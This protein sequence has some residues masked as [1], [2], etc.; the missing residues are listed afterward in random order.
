M[1]AYAGSWHMP[2]ALHLFAIAH[3][4]CAQPS[5]FELTRNS[6]LQTIPLTF[7]LALVSSPLVERTDNSYGGFSFD[8]TGDGTADD[9]FVA[10]FDQANEVLLSDGAGGYSRLESGPLVERTDTSYG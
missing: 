7:H 10:N 9:V 3:T 8:A 2:L 4:S 1:M 5:T 6:T